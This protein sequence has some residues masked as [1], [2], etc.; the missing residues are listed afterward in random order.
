MLDL[1]AAASR[2]LRGKLG[3]SPPLASQTAG[4]RAA[5]SS[6][7]NALRFYFLG[8]EALRIHEGARQRALTQAL[9]EDP[10]FAL[11][12][13]VLSITWRVLG[14]DLRA[15]EE[16][17]RAFDLSG[18]LG[19]EDQLGVEGAYYE[20]MSDWPKAIEKYQA[21][22][23]FFPDNIAY[24]LK[25]V[26][27]QLLGGRLDEARRVVEQMK[28][29]PPPADSDPRVNVVAGDLAFRLGNFSDALAEGKLTADKATAKKAS[30]LQ[31]LGK[32]RQ[33]NAS[34]RL[35]QLDDARRYLADAKQIFERI[36]D[37][38]GVGD[39][40]RSDAIVLL[41]LE[42]VDEA[43]QQLDRALEMA[44]RI[45]NLRLAAE[46]RINRSNVAREQG[47]LTTAKTDAEAAMAGASA[48]NRSGLARGQHA[49][50][51][52]LRL[53][54]EY[55]AA[56]ARFQESARLAAEIGEKPVYTAAVNSLAAL[57]LA[58]GRTEDARRRLDEI[59]PVDRPMGDKGALAL[60]LANLSALLGMQ[61]HLAEAGKA[62]AE[63]CAI[64]ESLGAA[65]AQAGCRL[66][67]AALWIDEGRVADARAAADRIAAE[68]S[69]SLSPID[70][71]TQALVHLRAGDS[72]KAAATI[73]AAR[74]AIEGRASIPEQAIPIAIAEARID[75]AAG[76]IAEA[77][78]A[79][80][81]ATSE[82][83]RLGLRPLALDARSAMA[84]GGARSGAARHIAQQKNQP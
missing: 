40:L 30:Q 54:G 71:A 44:T 73:A 31:A 67:L 61:G 41:A 18:R 32:L 83:E 3:L 29:L 4:L 63:E 48:Q 47:R 13:S 78:Q 6:N 43:A 49:L 38:G 55:V 74:R 82:A 75:I 5:L 53:Q 80:T 39:S 17:R 70:L 37:T 81:Q 14:Y 60:R 36:G 66:R 27:Q 76:R 24:A 8:L 15:Q 23:N 42:R 11:A 12:H 34:H 84:Q 57:D 1:V 2:E 10:N 69:A 45:N 51:S 21:L 52:V 22:W 62:A 7:P 72:K 28:A 65:G 77:Q 58:E 16:A 35:G 59:L 56:R 25:L 9:T 33:G 46:I 79:L 19:R 68:S 26:H 64:H 50:G 20:V